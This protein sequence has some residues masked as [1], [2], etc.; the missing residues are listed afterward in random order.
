MPIYFYRCEDCGHKFDFFHI[1]SDDVAQCPKCENKD[2]E[3][4]LTA[5]STELFNFPN[6]PV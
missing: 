5:H 2:L 4:L 6:I 3:K 1:K